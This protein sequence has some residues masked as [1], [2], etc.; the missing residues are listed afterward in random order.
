MGITD[1]GG[2]K[3]ARNLSYVNI[4][5]GGLPNAYEGAYTAT[6]VFNHPVNGPRDINEDKFLKSIDKKHG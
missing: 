2:L 1:A 3:I 5:V 6:G 4:G